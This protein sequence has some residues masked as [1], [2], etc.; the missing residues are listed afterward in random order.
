MSDSIKVYIRRTGVM[1]YRNGNIL[2]GVADPSHVPD[3]Y[4]GEAFDNEMVVEID[5]LIGQTKLDF[6]YYEI[7]PDSPSDTNQHED[8]IY[9]FDIQRVIYQEHHQVIIE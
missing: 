3:T 5:A 2:F 4:D 6:T 9:G 8:T 1:D 7:D